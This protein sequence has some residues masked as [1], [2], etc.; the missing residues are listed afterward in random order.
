V[1]WSTNGSV[2]ETPGA[3]PARL[4]RGTFGRLGGERQKRPVCRNLTSRG[5]RHPTRPAGEGIRSK[6]L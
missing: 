3:I 6:K 4:L 2:V 1:T 5:I